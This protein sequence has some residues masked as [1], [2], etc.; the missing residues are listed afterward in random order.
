MEARLNSTALAIHGLSKH[1]GAQAALSD[2]ALE[3]RAG[4]VHA[5]LGQNGSGKSTLIKVLA[6]FHAPEGGATAEAFGAALAL[7][8]ADAARAAGIRFVHQDLALVGERDVTDNL[9]LGTGYDGRRWLRDRRERRAAQELLDRLGIA[10]RADRLVKDLSP[11]QQT[12]IAVARAV[13]A[14]LLVLDEVSAALAKGELDI[15]LDLVRRIRAQGG[16]ILFVTHRLEEVFALADRVTVLRDGR[17]VAT[18]DVDGLTADELVEL[19]VGR[20][21]RELY[22]D[23]PAPRNE[24]VL[25]ARGLSG[26]IVRDF[27]LDVHR[28]EIVGIAGLTGSGRDELP[29]LLFGARPWHAGELEVNGQRFTRISPSQAIRA[30]LALIPADRATQGATPSLTLRANVTLP[31]V[32]ATRWA[33]IRAGAEAAEADA[34]LRKL[35][36]TP[37]E[38]ETRLAALSGGNQQKVVLARWLR[39]DPSVLLLDEPTQG[40]DIGSKAAIYTQIADRARRGVAALLAS[41]DHE[42][43]A[44]LGDRVLVLRDGRVAAQLYGP[45]LTA[46][47]I[48][49]HVLAAGVA[50]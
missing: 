38:P 19:I 50:R 49:E 2:V 32:P 26:D 25:I 4:E 33:W 17:N 9:A 7:G 13:P 1:F 8:D 11:A 28:G 29:Y 43:L 44:A 15:V 10:V 24:R 6:G 21:L 30:G 27:D 22:P 23:P 16:T 12:M 39:C 18:R 31:S 48:D 36:V 46:H 14:R 34:W 20:R 42:E 35:E 41:T 45:A 3:L 40:I 5:L 37:C 47:D